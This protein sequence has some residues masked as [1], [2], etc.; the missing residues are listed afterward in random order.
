MDDVSKGMS[1]SRSKAMFV[2]NSDGNLRQHI[3]VWSFRKPP[4][5]TE[6]EVIFS[7]YDDCLYC[8]D[9]LHRFLPFDQLV[10]TNLIQF[11][12]VAND[13]GEGIGSLAPR[14]NHVID[15]AR[16]SSTEEFSCALLQLG[17][18]DIQSSI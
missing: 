10:V 4:G 12:F 1:K 18:E 14:P 16:F 11:V 15:E 3:V 2:R 6:L 13:E 8:W 5:F 17:L 9:L 7:R